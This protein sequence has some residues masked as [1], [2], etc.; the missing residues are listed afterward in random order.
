MTKI[1]ATHFMPARIT[2]PINPTTGKDRREVN[3]M[4]FLGSRRGVI[5][6][7]SVQLSA[8]DKAR[9]LELARCRQQSDLTTQLAVLYALRVNR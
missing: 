8:A 4:E 5:K 3:A 1:Y 9:L 2:D 7:A 6:R